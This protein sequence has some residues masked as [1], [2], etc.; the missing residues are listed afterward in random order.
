MGNYWAKDL[1]KIA[2]LVNNSTFIGLRGESHSLRSIFSN[3]ITKKPSLLRRL[4]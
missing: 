2:F 4:F 1:F 3:F